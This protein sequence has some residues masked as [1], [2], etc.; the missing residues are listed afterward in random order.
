MLDS[1]YNSYSSDSPNH[2]DRTVP[3]PIFGA[4]EGSSTC[5]CLLHSCFARRILLSGLRTALREDCGVSP[6]IMLSSDS[7]L[8]G[9]LVS[10]RNNTRGGTKLSCLIILEFSILLIIPSHR[11][12]I[13]RS[14][15]GV[16]IL[17]ECSRQLSVTRLIR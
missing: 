8:I 3:S 14:G 15:Q 6:D 13:G 1:P 16:I 17:H 10:F 5:R 4:A 12:V 11:L 7:F 9:N 2:P